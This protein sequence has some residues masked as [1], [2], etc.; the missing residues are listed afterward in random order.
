MDQCLQFLN[1][2]KVFLKYRNANVLYPDHVLGPNS[3]CDN[4]PTLIMAKSKFI[5][6]PPPHQGPSGQLTPSNV[7]GAA[8]AVDYHLAPLP[9]AL[10]PPSILKHDHCIAMS[11]D[12]HEL[13]PSFRKKKL[14]TWT[15]INN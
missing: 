9:L 12:T 14:V 13:R 4:W 8:Q 11:T 15:T 3:P 2:L 10:P 7:G 6:P 5:L 1:T